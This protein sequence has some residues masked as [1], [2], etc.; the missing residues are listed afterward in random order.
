MS[1]LNEKI[2][3]LLK[4]SLAYQPGDVSFPISRNVIRLCEALQKCIKR[5]ND[6]IGS[7]MLSGGSMERY[8]K[9]F[10]SELYEILSSE[11]S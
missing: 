1:D 3:A 7:C 4:N 8:E 11:E 9:Q 10:D 6:A 5:R 2:E